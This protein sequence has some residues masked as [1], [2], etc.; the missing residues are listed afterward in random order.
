MRRYFSSTLAYSRRFSGTFI[1]ESQEA[2]QRRFRLSSH[3]DSFR[4]GPW[5]IRTIDSPKKRELLRSWSNELNQTY[6]QTATAEAAQDFLAAHGVTELDVSDDDWHD[7]Q[8]AVLEIISS[9]PPSQLTSP[10]LHTVPNALTSHP[11]AYD[12][13]DHTSWMRIDDDTEPMSSARSIQESSSPLALSKEFVD[14]PTKPSITLQDDRNDS[15]PSSA[16]AVAVPCGIAKQSLKADDNIVAP[17]NSKE[18]TGSSKRSTSIFWC[19]FGSKPV[20]SEK[21]I[22]VQSSLHC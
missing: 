22:E 6:G 1:P 5:N 19:C 14:S 12:G 18:T 13:I 11:T 17:A 16:A 20:T 7:W 2:F 15:S 8:D 4:M 21:V 3:S 9:Q 10:H